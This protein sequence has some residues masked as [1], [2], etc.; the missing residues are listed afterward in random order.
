MLDNLAVT[1]P[2]MQSQSAHPPDATVVST[3]LLS[4]LAGGMAWGIRGQYGH[5]TGAMIAGL[6]VGLVLVLQLG[7]GLTALGAIRAV[8]MA[9]IAMGFGGSMTYGQ[10]VGLTHDAALVGNWAALRWGLLGLAIKGGLWIGFCGL[11]LGAGL[12][13][14]RYRWRE[15]VGI[16]AGLL[17]CYA[18]GV[19]LLNR[20]FDPGNKVLPRIYFSASW[21][22]LPQAT[23]K[24]RPECWGGFLFALVGGML[25]MGRFKRDGLAVRMALWGLSGGAL[26]FPIGQCIQ[27]FHAWNPQLFAEGFGA[28]LQG[29]MNWW[30]WMETTFGFVMG[31][32]LGFGLWRNRQRIA[33]ATGKEEAPL[34]WGVE[35]IWVAVH[36]I[37]MV[38]EEFGSVGWIN[39]F[40]DP[41]LI[42]GF[43][44]MVAVVSG[45]WWPFWLAL[46]VTVIPIAGK[47]LRNLVM[48]ASWMTPWVGWTVFVVG[49]VGVAILLAWR[50]GRRARAGA[51]AATVAAPMLLATAG[52]YF[53]LNYAF[54]RFP[55]PWQPWTARTPNSLFFIVALLALLALAHRRGKTSGSDA[56]G[57]VSEEVS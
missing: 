56:D 23:L 41:G 2:P 12:G 53:G 57:R 42:L 27:A 38:W 50:L 45:R 10:T 40:Y 54:F 13:G 43:I 51:G 1:P 9:T 33:E 14:V 29:V 17:V 15:M 11:F 52:M 26:G 19:W 20:P 35:F 7:R 34:P 18:V 47:T 55:W 22:W 31:G 46:P 8:A 4:A 24:P 16:M 25:W 49:P 21:E 28:R 36:T 39:A 48:E 37:L 6:L 44:P 30:N 32:T 5:E 3:V